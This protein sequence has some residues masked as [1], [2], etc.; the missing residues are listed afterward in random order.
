MNIDLIGLLSIFFITLFVFLI[1]RRNKSIALILYFALGVRILAIFFNQYMMILPDSTGDA[2]IFEMR[3][4][5]WSQNG[6]L[7]ALSHFPGFSS[8]FISWIIAILYS[9]FGQSELMAQSLSLFFGVATVYLGYILTEK[10]WNK[11]SAIKTG[12][13]LALF[14]SLILYSCL[15]LR[16]VYIYFFLLVALNGVVNWSDSKSLKSLILVIIGFICS[17]FYHSAM[18]IGL[19]IFFSI[20]F[21][22]NI[23]IILLNLNKLKISKRSFI[24]ILLIISITSFAHIGEVK[25]QKIPNLFNSPSENIKFI[26]E[27]IG[28]FN[29]GTAKYPS[30]LVPES[31]SE[32]I[33]KSPFRIIYFVFSPFPWDIKKYSH[34]IGMFDGFIYIYLSYLIWRNRHQ[35]LADPAL[36][37][38]L[39]L[40]ISYLIVYG[41]GVGNFGTGIRHRSKFAVMFIILAAPLLPKIVLNIK[42][43]MF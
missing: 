24:I 35:I 17:T 7:N 13:L 39:M 41:I 40:L 26:L 32:L 28:H 18:I 5:E 12:W 15:V 29:K 16:E 43:K 3:A 19:F 9:V 36:K 10:I 31:T 1:A 33:Y 4:L 23:K 20:I 37:I 34:L 11:R 27:K 8:F 25:F 38:I 14:P 22:Q 21:L 2:R 6:L 42:K 30:W